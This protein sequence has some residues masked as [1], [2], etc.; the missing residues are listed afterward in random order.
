MSTPWQQTISNPP[1][2]LWPT[3]V[4]CYTVLWQ[5][6]C[7]MSSDAS[8]HVVNIN[9]ILCNSTIYQIEIAFMKLH[10]FNYSC[11]WHAYLKINISYEQNNLQIIC[12]SIIWIGFSVLLL[13]VDIQWLKICL[14]A[15]N[16]IIVHNSN[17]K[18]PDIYLVPLLNILPSIVF[19]QET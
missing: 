9:Y 3:F 13:I 11:T 1:I 14:N 18:T 15:Y 4:P 12:F 2:T 19:W 6:N 5:R 16:K 7:V 17:V 10:W 8:D